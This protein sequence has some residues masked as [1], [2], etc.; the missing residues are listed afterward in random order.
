MPDGIQKEILTEAEHDTKGSDGQWNSRNIV[1]YASTGSTVRH[2]LE[3]GRTDQTLDT[4]KTRFH[5]AGAR[6]EWRM[7][8]W[9][10]GNS[11]AD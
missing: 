11:Q 1:R 4:S 2:I 7:T 9:P 10:V 5:G 8:L 6:S 3:A